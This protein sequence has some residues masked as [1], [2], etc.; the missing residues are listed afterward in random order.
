M[1]RSLLVVISAVGL[2]SLA[3]AYAQTNDTSPLPAPQEGVDTN[4][5]LPG[6]NSYTEAQVKERL[7]KNGFSAVTELKLDDQGIWRGKAEQGGKPW[8]VAVDYR[9]N[10]TY[11]GTI[12]AEG[13]K[14]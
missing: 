6:A 2:L 11:S 9:G 13:S 5:P 1:K 4:A 3:P 7:E 8:Q 12:P 10:I 14:S